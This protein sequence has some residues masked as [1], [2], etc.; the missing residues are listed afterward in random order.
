MPPPTTVQTPE[1]FACGAC[2]HIPGAGE[3][4]CFNSLHVTGC[5]ELTALIRQRDAAIRAQARAEVFRELA[6]EY[7]ELAALAKSQR[8]DA[9]EQD[10]P[11]VANIYNGIY[12][13]YSGQVTDI[14]RRATQVERGTDG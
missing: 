3:A 14:R 13:A 12:V 4:L 1:E 10:R 7:S 2:V 5:K 9:D 8:D 6:G 11:D